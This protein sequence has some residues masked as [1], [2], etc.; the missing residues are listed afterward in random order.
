[1]LLLSEILRTYHFNVKFNDRVLGWLYPS[2]SHDKLSYIK[3]AVKFISGM[4]IPSDSK[5]GIKIFSSDVIYRGVDRE[6][7]SF[8]GNCLW[9]VSEKGGLK[10]II[11]KNSDAPLGCE[12]WLDYQELKNQPQVLDNLTLDSLKH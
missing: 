12:F 4:T 7:K 6:G 2:L 11:W 3:N 1:M 8:M 5:F 9:T 10:T